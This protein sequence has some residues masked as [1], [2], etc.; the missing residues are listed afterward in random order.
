MNVTIRH[1]IEGLQCPECKFPMLVTRRY[2][3][4]H[5]MSCDNAACKHYGVKYE[6]PYQDFELKPCKHKEARRG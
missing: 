6:Q 3:Q 1:Y 5:Q 4:V 2:E